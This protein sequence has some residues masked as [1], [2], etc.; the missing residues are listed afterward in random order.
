MSYEKIDCRSHRELR[1]TPGWLWNNQPHI[2][3]VKVMLSNR[4]S[5]K[6]GIRQ[7]EACSKGKKRR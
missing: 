1:E 3:L 7:S 4:G 5:G 6:R 2:M